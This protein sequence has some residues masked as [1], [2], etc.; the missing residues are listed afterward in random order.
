MSEVSTAHG[1]LRQICQAFNEH[2]FQS[3]GPEQAD[4]ELESTAEEKI[5]AVKLAAG[6]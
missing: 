2:G 6:M 3:I 5:Q 1:V 4:R